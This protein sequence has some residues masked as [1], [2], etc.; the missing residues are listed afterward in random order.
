M[1]QCPRAAR[2]GRRTNASVLVHVLLIA[3]AAA[4]AAGAHSAASSSAAGGGDWHISDCP[5]AA[6]LEQA[7][8]AARAAGV[9]NCLVCLNQRVAAMAA[10]C[11]PVEADAFCSGSPVTPGTPGAAARPTVYRQPRYA[12]SNMS[13]VVYG[14]GL[15]CA[16]PDRTKAAGC[17]PMDLVL[18]TYSPAAT[19]PTGTPRPALIMMHGGG[20][21]GG[22]KTDAWARASSVFYAS[23]G[24]ACFSIKYR[25]DT[26]THHGNSPR[27]SLPDPE[28]EE[29]LEIKMYPATRDLKAAIRFVRANAVRFNV[30]PGRIALAGGSAGAISSIAAG[31]VD[32]ADY[33]NELLATVRH[34]LYSCNP[35]G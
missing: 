33:K 18:D 13:N 32:E 4:R 12:V 5:T 21:A 6:V 19:P 29:P 30:D 9:G 2:G 34:G 35:Y 10:S 23:R 26:G 17:T 7:C 11:R 16:D 25:L 1:T 31:V 3:A 20:W 28:Q 14:Q 15:Q 22:S 24:F 8:G 27:W